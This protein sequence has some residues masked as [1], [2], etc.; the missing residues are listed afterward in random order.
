V[1]LEKFQ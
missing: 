1:F